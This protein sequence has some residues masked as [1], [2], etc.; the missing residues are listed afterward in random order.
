MADVDE[1]VRLEIPARPVYVGVARS[2]VVAVASGLEGLDI[3]RLEDLRLAVSE[4]CTNAIEA[5]QGIDQRVVLRCLASG[6]SLE[7]SIEDNGP[8]FEPEPSDGRHTPG[9]TDAAQ[10]QTERG[11]GLQL[12]RALVDDVTFEPSGPGTAVRLRLDLSGVG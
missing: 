1:L 2:V 9:Q 10:M 6:T 8:G 7:V 4:A 5:Q 3:D 12:I 11:W